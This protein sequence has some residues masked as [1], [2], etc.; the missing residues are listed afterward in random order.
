MIILIE[1]IEYL[2]SKIRQVTFRQRNIRR[3]KQF[4]KL[5]RQRSLAERAPI[6]E[7]WLTQQSNSAQI[8]DQERNPGTPILNIP[9]YPPW[10]K[11][12]GNYI[13]LVIALLK[14]TYWYFR[15]SLIYH[16]LV[17]R[18]LLMRINYCIYDLT[19][20][21]ILIFIPAPHFVQKFIWVPPL[22]SLP[23]TWQNIFTL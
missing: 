3:R 14:F 23:H 20:K 4:R 12:G 19:N 21:K 13:K 11:S 17:Q 1:F 9:E 7:W 2:S 10:D 15:P 8:S 18:S 6:P 5:V 22:N 16:A